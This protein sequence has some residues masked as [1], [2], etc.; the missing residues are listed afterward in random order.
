VETHREADR[1]LA[2]H[3][4]AV[5]SPDQ[6]DRWRAMLGLALPFRLDPANT[7]PAATVDRETRPASGSESR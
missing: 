1:A 2:R 6:Q 7:G 3:A 4:L 5:M